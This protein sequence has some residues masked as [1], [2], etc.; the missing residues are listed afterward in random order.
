M[1]LTIRNWF[2]S[3]HR[4]RRPGVS[5]RSQFKVELAAGLGLCLLSMALCAGAGAQTITTTTVQGTVY[6]AT[7]GVGSGTL[8]L[9]WPSFTTASGQLITADTTTVIIPTNG[10]VSVNL[11]P[12]V[13]ATPAGLY[14]TA[15]YYLS[16]GTT[17]TQYWAVPAA[18]SATIAQVQSQLM[19]AA[20]AVQTVSQAYVEEQIAELEGSLLTASGGTLTGPLYL[21]GDPT[22]PLQAADKH[23]VDITFAEA[24][25]LAGGAATGPLTA[26]QLGAAYQADQF[27]GANFGAKLQVCINT[28]SSTYGGTCDARNFTGSQSMSSNLSISKQNVNVLLPCATITT[29]NQIVVTAGTRN[30]SLRGCALR[31][32]SSASGS[33]GGTAF[34]YSGTAAMVQVGD[35]TYAV[36]TQGFHL[37]NVVINTTASTSAAAQGFVAYRTQELNLEELYFLG[38]ANQ[39]GMTLD[40]TENYTGGSF[41]ANHFSGF[42]TALN[43]I[44][45]QVANAATTDW[46][47]ASTFVRLHIDCPTSSGNPISGTYGINLQQGDGNAFTGGDV[48]GCNT[49]LHLGPNAQNNTI[50]GLRNE[51]SNNQVVTD[52]GSSYNN[53]MAGGTIF[54]GQLTDN[55]ERNSFLDTFHRSFNGLT[56][57]WYGSQQDATVT[58]HQRL[59]IGLGNERG[60]LTEYQTDYGYRWEDGLTDGTSGLQFYNI[61]DVL[62]NVPRLSIGQYLS[63]TPNTVTNVMVNNGGCYSTSTAPTI[64]FTG[65]GGTGA[66]ATA[67]MAASSSVSCTTFRI[68]TITVTAGGSSYTSQPTVTFTASNQASAPNA[69]AEIATSGGTNN[70]SVINAAGTGAVVLN[71]SNNSGTGGTVFGSGGSSESTVATISNAGNAQFNGTL[72]VGGISQL[73]GTLSVR[74]NADAEVDY[75]LWPGL[76]TSQKGSYTYK[77]WNG[78]SQWYMVKDASNN[79]ALNSALGGL[80]SFKAY[81][82]TNSGDTY[83]DASNSSGFVRINYE[84]GSGT[85]FNIYGG[86]SSALYASFTGTTAIKF[87]GLAAASG[88]NCLQVDNSGYLTNTGSACGTSSGSGSGTVN[89]A[90]SGQIAYYPSSGTTVGGVSQVPVSAGGT[91]AST[92][93]AALTALGAQAAIPGLSSDGSNGILV[94]ANGTFGG[95]VAAATVSAKNLASI[96]PR[97]DVTQFGALGNNSTDDTAAIQAAFT[98]CWNNSNNTVPGSGNG[99]VVEFPGGKQYVITSTVY[100]YDSC[101]LE[102]VLTSQAPSIIKWNGPAAGAVYNITSFTAAANATPYYPAY[103]PTPSPAPAATITFPITNSVSVNNW[104]LIRGFSTST[105]I[106]I[107]NTVAQVVAASG[108]SFTVVVPYSPASTGTITDTGTVTTLNVMFA[109]DTFSRY[110]EDIRDLEFTNQAGIATANDAG[111]DFYFGSRVDTGTK[112]WGAWAENPLYY[113]FYFSQGGIDIDFDKGWRGDNPGLAAIYW[114]VSGGD[115]FGIANGTVSSNAGGTM[116]LDNSAC[117]SGALVRVTSRNMGLE[118]ESSGLSSGAGEF[119]LLDCPSDVFPGQFFLD[120]ENTRTAADSGSVNYS[121]IVMSPPNDLALNLN[122]VNGIFPNGVSPNTTQRWVGIPSLTRY[123]VSG[124]NGQIPSLTYAPSLTSMGS[125]TTDY[126]SARAMS[127]CM[128]DCNIGQLWQYGI[129]ASAFLYSDTAYAALPNATTLYAG[130]I[131]APPAYWSGVNG[132]RYALDVVYQAGTTGTPNGG[133]TTCKTTSTADQFLCTSATDLNSGQHIAVGANTNKVIQY[134]DATNASNVLVWTT[135]SLSTVSSFTALTFAAPVLGPEIQMPTKS[136]SAPASLAWSQGDTQQNS[137]ATANGVAAWVNVAA[138]TP[139]TWAGIPLGNSSG[140]IAPSQ[141]SATTG[142]GSVVLASGPTFTGNTTTFVNSAAAEQDVTIQPGTG[143]DQVGAFAFNNYAGTSQWKLRKDA[144]NYLRITDVV[145][146]LDRAVF[147]QNGQTVLNAGAGANP[148]VVNGSTGSGTSGLLVESGGSSPAAVLTVSGSGNTTAAGFVSGKFMLGSGT[149][150]LAANAAAGTSPTIA[151]ATSHVCDGVSGTVTLTTGT[152]TTTGTLATLSFPN[153]HSNDA[154]C[155]VTPTLSST[156]LVSTISW[157][158]STTALTLTANAALTASTAYQVRYWCGGN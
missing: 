152:S 58:D 79:W 75:Y 111:V 126:N 89:P 48:E 13:G 96:G 24:L 121:S 36:D 40:G 11:A 18:T 46:L 26:L 61:L 47:N 106:T 43:A 98:A 130:Q 103:S 93:A 76:T 39:T 14:Y 137:A 120:M 119:A 17:S 104:V 69:V 107:N 16:D 67:V 132:N 70:Q 125:I 87:P 12:N 157:S 108:S 128:G 91:G 20:Q 5:K 42:Q 6:L 1:K 45:H 54:T 129:P 85:G 131:L 154:N 112:I 50:V 34:L 140:Q 88:H 31:G 102:G 64:G 97:Y 35:P 114:R 138:G 110:Y 51:N 73:A 115:N 71:G 83:V 99:G 81:Q 10:L 158:E 113:G 8:V 25:P 124:A 94:T 143:A 4:F 145:N 134:V 90:T 123:D 72:T 95:T 30:V 127:Q 19:P 2:R 21:S 60:R 29:P 80:D 66:A 9:S 52:A 142:S 49:A 100:T 101:R 135:A 148:A 105:G 147:F 149:M 56:G 92:A 144:S 65:G 122:I 133:A 74:N 63:T 153:T 78:A 3:F 68:S 7:G 109:S 15:V 37:D 53:W 118:V 150:S 41:F 27:P 82:S 28:L 156:G 32:G 136:A 141:I 139:G 33:Q 116:V 38:N 155:V 86:S 151:C 57:D 117:N 84:T 146:A 44:G 59:G 22:Q 23:Y 77:D 55:G 62:N